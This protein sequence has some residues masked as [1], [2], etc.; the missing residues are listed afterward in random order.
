MANIILPKAWE[1]IASKATPENIYY[2]RREILKQM[3]IVTGGLLAGASLSSC[4]SG[5]EPNEV[6]TRDI[7]FTFEGMDALYPAPRN[8]AY[9]LDREISNE[10]TVT[11]YNNFYEFIHPNDTNIYNVYKYINAF[12]TSDWTIEVSG[13][14]KNKG[15]FHLGDLIKEMGLEERTYRHRCVEAWA[16]AVPWTGFPFSKLIEF[17]EPENS[18]THIRME[19]YANSDQM[20]GVAT[21]DWYPW[22]YFEGLRME[23]AMNELSFIATG[24]Y[25]KPMPK[26][27]GAPVRL[28]TPWKYGYKSIKS[29]VKMEF[30]NFQPETFWHTI[31]P[32]EYGFLSNVNP[33]VPH[34]RWSQAEERM[35]PDGD[36]R[37]TLLYNGYGDFVADLY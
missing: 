30:V 15:V 35:I 7:N 9:P 11:H 20:V 23:E 25:G 32:D 14:V 2:N 34:P 5:E 24:L 19:S 16:M 4:E 26:Q 33:L 3:G 21:Q 22:P 31:A 13:K 37:P 17:F 10:H 8:T 36:L 6:I 27:N 1:R 29:I 18:A 12:D 28:V